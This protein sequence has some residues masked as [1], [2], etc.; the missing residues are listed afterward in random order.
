MRWNEDIAETVKVRRNDLLDKTGLE[1]N[2]ICT[3]MKEELYSMADC[4]SQMEY[5]PLQL[6]WLLPLE[7]TQGMITVF[8]NVIFLLGYVQKHG[9][10]RDTI[11]QII[12]NDVRPRASGLSNE[13]DFFIAAAIII[14]CSM[15]DDFS[16][17]DG[18]MKL[19]KEI[20][21]QFIGVLEKAL[22]KFDSENDSQNADRF[23]FGLYA[24]KK[25]LDEWLL[26][27]IIQ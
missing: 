17:S 5:E 1:E 2:R 19:V 16:D 12:E 11:G 4:E 23:V 20:I 14:M 9:C 3:V 10:G 15:V 13:Y 21:G 24:H 6:K 7:G 27:Q 18:L 8:K 25:K 26:N 22:E